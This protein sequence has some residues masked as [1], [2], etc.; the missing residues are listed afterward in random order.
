MLTIHHLS[1]SRSQKILWLAE[2]L[3][4]AYELKLYMRDPQTLSA[5]A[6]MKALH[7]L[8]TSPLIT[9]NGYT[10]SETGAIMDY[11][12]RHYGEGRLQPDADSVEFD[13]F[14]E[15]MHYAEGSAMLPMLVL[16][17]ANYTGSA[18]TALNDVMQQQIA[19]HMGY[20]EN[21]LAGVDYLVNNCF[22]AADIHVSFVGQTGHQYTDMSAYPNITAWI[23]RLEARPAYQQ[24]QQK[25]GYF[26]AAKP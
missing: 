20:I 18:T 24:A 1:N 22:S 6:E 13:Q 11:I 4:I 3:G 25:G 8:G 9:D 12:L 26:G 16:I 17:Y 5:P 21:A 15:W 19:K 23:A 2:E 10:Y 14:M 7:P